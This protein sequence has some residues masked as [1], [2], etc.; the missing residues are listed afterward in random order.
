ML[1]EERAA[2]AAQEASHWWFRARRRIVGRLLERLGVAQRAGRVADLGCGAGVDLRRLAL[3]AGV[4]V[5]VDAAA[6]MWSVARCDPPRKEGSEREAARPDPL[7]GSGGRQEWARKDGAA[8]LLVRGA[9]ERVPLRSARFDLVL[10]LDVLEHL[11]D[12]APAIAES[13]RLLAPGGTLVVSVPAWPFLWSEHD[14]ALG[15]KRRYRRADLG[16]RLAA[17]GLRVERVTYFNTFLFPVAL[18]Y[19]LAGKWAGKRTLKGTSAAHSRPPQS[20]T[21]RLGNRAG[22]VLEAVFAAERLWIG[23]LNA[24]FGVSLLAVARKPR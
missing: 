7:Q 11:D 1:S 17:A 13:A 6:G 2:L 18:A 5:G 22:A 15:H 12:D 21:R 4:R 14:E 8:V 10:A 23:R 9:A 3:A 20:D 24:P 19:R 16:R